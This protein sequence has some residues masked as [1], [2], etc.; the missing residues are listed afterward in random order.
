MTHPT[1]V[2]LEYIVAEYI[3]LYG[4]T[5][6][7]ADYF[8]STQLRGDLAPEENRPAQSEKPLP[9]GHDW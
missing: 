2:E 9:G 7:A 5:K 3:E 8:R 4:V 6:R 1:I